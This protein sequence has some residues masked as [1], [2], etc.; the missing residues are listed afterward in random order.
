LVKDSRTTDLFKRWVISGKKSSN[1]Y[2]YSSLGWFQISLGPGRM[3]NKT[4]DPLMLFLQL[5]P[6]A[7][8]LESRAVTALA[9]NATECQ[10]PCLI[11]LVIDWPNLCGSHSRQ[12]ILQI[13][14]ES[15]VAI[16]EGSVSIFLPLGK[17]PVTDC[18]SDWNNL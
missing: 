4:L 3:L 18:R 1:A 17:Y 7:A 16:E 14:L 11:M 6:S 13:W 5:H 8:F 15:T 2:L 12:L 10:P 9:A